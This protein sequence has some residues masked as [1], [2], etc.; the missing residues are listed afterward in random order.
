M[1]TKTKNNTIKLKFDTSWSYDPAPESKSAATIKP[2]YDLFIDGKWQKPSGKY[3]DTINPA[4]EEKLSE[5]ANA[6]EA[7]VDKAVKAARKAYDTTW[8]KMPAKE[9]AKYIFRIARMVQEKAR[10]LAIIES[11]DGGKPIRESRD[12]DVP[13]A[14]NHFFYYAGWAD[15]LEYAFP[16]RK[17]ESLGVAGQIIPWNFPLLMAAWKI[18]PALATG[19]TVVLKPAETTSLTALKLAEIIEESDLPPGVVNIVTG[20]GATGAAIVNHPDINKIAFT[21]STDVG[22]IIQRAI[23]GTQKKATLE[24]GGKAANI[25]FEDAPLDQAV[26]G[27][28]NGIFFNQGHV[29]CAGSR[30]YV[31]ESVAKQ[32]IRKLKDRLESLIVGDPMDKNTDIGAINSKQQLENIHKYLKIGK[33][34]GAEIYENS[35]PLPRKGFWCRP[36]LFI[37]VAQSSRIAQEEIFGPVLAILTFRTDDEVIEKANNSPYGLSAGVWTDKG[38]KIFN[39][40][41]RMRAGVVWANTF[42][43]FDPSS[44][45]GGYKESGFGREGGLHGLLPYL[46]LKV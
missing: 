22:K 35:C 19:N 37:N 45:F 21:G 20:A 46:D 26:E 11:L 10:E 27:V 12:F 44:P 40:T 38:S 14:A 29:C 41:K 15:K 1:A 6:T 28:I 17:A 33:Q 34:E 18:A 23:A 42:N 2:Q 43:K 5:I 9:R 36:T 32:V 31:Q 30:L 3:F 7:D 25:I 4:N 39:I 8:K 13:T 16:N 24:L